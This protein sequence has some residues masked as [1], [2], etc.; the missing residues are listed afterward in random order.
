TGGAAISFGVN[1]TRQF[2]FPS[3]SSRDL[4]ALAQALLPSLAAP[5]SPGARSGLGR[6]VCPVHHPACAPLSLGPPG[7]S[8]S[9]S[10]QPGP[11]PVLL[12]ALRVGGRC[13]PRP[14][15]LRGRS[16]D[17]PSVPDQRSDGGGGPRV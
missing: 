15:R 2:P 7:R 6:A 4:L 14:G 13:V 10:S 1:G 16:R 12:E 17:L 11:A 8:G 9:G 5:D 3:R